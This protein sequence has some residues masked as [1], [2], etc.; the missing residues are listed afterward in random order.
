ML[1]YTNVFSFKVFP[2]LHIYVRL[3]HSRSWTQKLCY[4]KGV[5]NVADVDQSFQLWITSQTFPRFRTGLKCF[6]YFYSQ[7]SRLATRI[8]DQLRV[9]DTEVKSWRDNRCDV[10]SANV[11]QLKNEA[12]SM[13]Q[14]LEDSRLL[15]AHIPRLASSPTEQRP[16]VSNPSVAESSYN[17]AVNFPPRYG[18][19]WIRIKIRVRIRLG[20]GLRLD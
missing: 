1:S 20:L 12:L 4:T 10:C 16:L 18:M 19:D 11:A 5:H 3:Q 17:H 9:P 13:V 8:F 6:K 14:T 15:A 7:G 2:N